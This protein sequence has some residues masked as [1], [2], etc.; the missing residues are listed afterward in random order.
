MTIAVDLRRKAT[1]QTK[2]TNN[3]NILLMFRRYVTDIMKM[4]MKE[5]N[6]EGNIL[7]D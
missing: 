1:K 6:D 4:C 2:K 7:I 3:Q 5:F